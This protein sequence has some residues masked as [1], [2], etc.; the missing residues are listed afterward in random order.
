MSKV[1]EFVR[2]MDKKAWIGFMAG[3]NYFCFFNLLC[4]LLFYGVGIVSTIL[5]FTCGILSIAFCMLHCIKE[6]RV[7][8]I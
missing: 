7:E 2:L 8:A 1:K 6:K 5:G 4:C 3:L